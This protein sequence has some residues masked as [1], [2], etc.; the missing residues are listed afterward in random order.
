MEVRSSG[1]R[2]VSTAQRVS[3]VSAVDGERTHFFRD[4]SGGGGWKAGKGR[5]G[6]QV[7]LQGARV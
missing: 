1:G 4:R 5:G 2:V 3:G 6:G 7:E